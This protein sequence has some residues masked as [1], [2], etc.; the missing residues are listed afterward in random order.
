MSWYN[1]TFCIRKSHSFNLDRQLS[2]QDK[3]V[4]F[5]LYQSLLQYFSY[6]ASGVCRLACYAKAEPRVAVSKNTFSFEIVQ[7]VIALVIGITGI[8]IPLIGSYLKIY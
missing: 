6:A 5:G 3:C 4:V 7:N 2:N 1:G 8:T